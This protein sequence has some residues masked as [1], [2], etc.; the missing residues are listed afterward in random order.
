MNAAKYILAKR[1]GASMN[2]LRSTIGTKG[3][4]ELKI[5]PFLN[6]PII[7]GITALGRS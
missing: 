4:H 1:E 7:P 5:Q 2:G 6:T 3:F